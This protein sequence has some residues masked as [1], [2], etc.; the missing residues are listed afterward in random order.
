MYIRSHVNQTLLSAYS[1]DTQQPLK[2]RKEVAATNR[3][4]GVSPGSKCAFGTSYNSS[5]GQQH[6]YKDWGC[7]DSKVTYMVARDL[8]FKEREEYLRR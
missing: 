4:F 6:P 3:L 7:T 1:I 2:R 5:E 8:S